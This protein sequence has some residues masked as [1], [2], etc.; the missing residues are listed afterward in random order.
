MLWVVDDQG[1]ANIGY[2]NPGH[3]HT[4]VA[5]A[6]AADGVV[7]ERQYAFPWC[8][9]SRASLM[10]GR[11]PY[12]C[13]QT[14]A[15]VAR[16]YKFLPAKLKELGY[17]AHAIGKW[18]LGN[19]APWQTPVGRG[20]D[21][22]FGYLSGT[23]DHW[24]QWQGTGHDFGC[25]GVDLY[26]STQPA[27]GRNNTGFG[28]LT[29]GAEAVAVIAAHDVSVPLF[30]FMAL[31]VMHTPAQVPPEFSAIYH[32]TG[33][34]TE[35]YAVTNGMATLADEALGN[36]T[37]ALKARGMWETTLLVHTSDN[38]GPTGRL[39]SRGSANNFPLRG[40][41]FN[42]F[43]GGVRVPG[44][45]AG[46]ALPSSARGRR[47]EGHVHLCDWYATF[48][49]LAGGDGADLRVGL[50][51][52]DSLDM[53][54]YLTGAASHSP[55][56]WTVLSS[57]PGEQVVYSGDECRPAALCGRD[58][59]WNA[60]LLDGGAYK[61]VLG[62]Q[63]SGIWQ[64]PTYPNASTDWDAER[65]QPVVCAEPG[66][67]FDVRSDPGEHHDLAALM[68][69]KAAEMRQVLADFNRTYHREPRV[70]DPGFERDETA[71]QAY[72]AS[73]GGF[74]GPYLND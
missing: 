63:S 72:V 30:L 6:L 58:A 28:S 7:L 41:K 10:T 34:Y 13:V 59:V 19:L 37:A 4:P 32:R 50:P 71:C 42:L 3:V 60:A 25:E 53:W 22:S 46:G 16:G 21:T 43:E 57:Q 15:F 36:V 55:R 17:A 44:F 38:G 5:D 33:N 27:Y 51:P 68:P 29:H 35:A 18:H 54:D 66:C 62:W 48:A 39:A 64:G 24:T 49:G 52:P 1:W 8:A 65:D 47:L 61:L 40:G 31:Q 73:H 67:L 14:T 69:A 12:H 23:E 20:F 74:L 11:L 45:V 56:K 9:P 70:G 26:A 2:N